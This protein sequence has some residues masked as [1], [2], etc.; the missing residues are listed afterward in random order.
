ME[1]WSGRMVCLCVCTCR[2][3]CRRTH[4][5][6]TQSCCPSIF[7]LSSRFTANNLPPSAGHSELPTMAPMFPEGVQEM[8]ACTHTYTHTQPGCHI[9]VHMES[10]VCI[11]FRDPC[12]VTWENIVKCCNKHMG[13][14]VPF[15]L[16][17]RRWDIFYSVWKDGNTTGT[18]AS[19]SSML[20]ILTKE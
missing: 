19:V 11:S 20:V 5:H 12:D 9:K 10:H 18:T 15:T 16:A 17:L 8:Q 4:T 13:D 3:T 7:G 14:Q 1:D 2:L 6:T